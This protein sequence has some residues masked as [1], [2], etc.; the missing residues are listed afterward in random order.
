M[1]EVELHPS[2]RPTGTEFTKVSKVLAE[3]NGMYFFECPGCGAPHGINTGARPGPAWTF[4]GDLEKP[5]FSP[6]VL[7][8]CEMGVERRKHVCHSFVTN[9]ELRFLS[10]CTHEYA[11]QTVPLPEWDTV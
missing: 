6:S 8:S 3:S 4:N 1:E 7:C 11:G 5:T 10:D 9:G 2:L